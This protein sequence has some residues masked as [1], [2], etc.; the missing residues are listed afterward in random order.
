MMVVRKI[1][2]GPV[3]ARELVKVASKCDFDIDIL[4][5]HIYIDAKSILGVLALDF[6]QVLTISYNGTDE[7]LEAFLS[8]YAIAS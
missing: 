4:Y 2:L 5:Q 6:S 7:K 8:N 3:E 1:S